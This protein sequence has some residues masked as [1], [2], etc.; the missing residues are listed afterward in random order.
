[1]E[2]QIIGGNL[3]VAVLTME[4]GE[5]VITE[6]GGMSWMTNNFEMSTNMEGGLFKGLTRKLA[7]ES[8][9]MTRYTCNNGQG[10]I[11]F[12]SSF[13][14]EIK[15]IPLEA[16]QSL[17]CQKGAFLAGENSVNLEMHFRKKLGSG[18]FGGEGFILQK[19]TGPGMVF[20]EIDGSAVEYELQ[21]GQVMK[22]DTGNIAM[23]EPTVNFN[24]EMVK[25]FKNMF[26]G[27]EGL[28]ISSLTG[29]GKIWLQTM[30]F[31]NLVQR[32]IPHIPTSSA[33]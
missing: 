1:M 25:G 10:M 28:F 17:I 9:F 11:S 24:V 32:I 23:F 4:A 12:S 22:V 5:T 27:G 16:G 8:M 30:P 3:P 18:L 7:G 26:F 29:P 20:V 21:P 13:P 33:D 19:V 2:H 31:M 6:S 14:G 15:A